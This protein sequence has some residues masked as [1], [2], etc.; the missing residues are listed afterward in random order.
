MIVELF[1][2]LS[3]MK[4]LTFISFFS[5]SNVNGNLR[6]E[7]DIIKTFED[8]ITAL[9]NT[10]S[11]QEK[12]IEKLE[13]H[14]KIKEKDRSYE[15]GG[16]IWFKAVRTSPFNADGWTTLTYEDIFSSNDCPINI[17]SGVFTAPVTGTVLIY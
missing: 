7:T 10:I 6:N 5:L 4:L 17:T 3:I 11:A 13:S 2:F 8:K 14:S 15:N 16:V 12:R 1:K 9:E